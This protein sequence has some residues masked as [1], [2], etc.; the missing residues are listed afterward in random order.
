M[1]MPKNLL[2]YVGSKAQLLDVIHDRVNRV[3]SKEVDYIWV[4][5]FCGSMSVTLHVLAACMGQFSR[6]LVND[7]NP[8]L[9]CFFQC[10]QT[11]DVERI[12]EALKKYTQP[13]QR[14]VE[15]RKKCYY[16]Y[17]EELNAMKMKENRGWFMEHAKVDAKCEFV[18]KFLII[19]RTCF[20]GVSRY[21]KSGEFNVPMGT[22]QPNW[23]ELS[24]RLREVS[25]LITNSNVVFSCMSYEAFLSAAH[26]AYGAS[27][28]F[29]YC[30]PPYDDTFNQYTDQQGSF[31]QEKLFRILREWTPPTRYW[32]LHNTWNT[33]MLDMYH[34]YH[35]EAVSVRRMVSTR[36]STRGVVYEL[37]ATN[38]H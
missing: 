16:Q 10:I 19:N 7:V 3:V 33:R 25:R 2:Q 31:C 6:F 17:R 11:V 34:A 23:N 29:V 32:L 5:P 12:M 35:P 13:F 27:R 9:V 21:N 36:A 20:N 38:Y 22:S 8:S 26:V 37:L 30:D 24:E 18:C 15:E 28:W 1:L 4:E 14:D